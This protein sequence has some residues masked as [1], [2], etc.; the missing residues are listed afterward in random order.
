ME[1]IKKNL[2]A[3][4]L[5]HHAQHHHSEFFPN[6]TLVCPVQS[7]P[8]TEIVFLSNIHRLDFLMEAYSVHCDEHV[9]T[10][11]TGC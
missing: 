2:V 6:D 1:R 4:V 5:H 11:F 8:H 9:E 10:F 3:S 7:S